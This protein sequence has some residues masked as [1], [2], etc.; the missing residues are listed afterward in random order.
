MW[1]PFLMI[2]IETGSALEL[3]LLK[4]ERRGREIDSK[5]GAPDCN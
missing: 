1:W 3:R 5:A 2:I 4:H